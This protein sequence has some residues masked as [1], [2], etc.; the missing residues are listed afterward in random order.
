[1][2]PEP[3]LD[4]LIESVADGRPIDWQILEAAAVDDR[5]RRRLRQLKLVAA[6]AEVHSSLPDDVADEAVDSFEP[7]TGHTRW[8][9]LS[10][11]DKIG[12]GGFGEVFHARDPW[13]DRDVAL[14]LLKAAGPSDPAT[15]RVL[16]EARTLARIR[17]P[18]V[19]TVYGADRHDARGGMWME[20]VRGRTLADLL[21]KHG[22]FS[23]REAASVCVDLCRALAAIH[24][25]GLVHRDIKAQNVMRED[26]GRIVLMDLGNGRAIRAANDRGKPDLTGTP[27]YLAPEL[28]DGTPA[29]ERS[30]LYSLGVL[31]YHLV[32]DSYPVQAATLDDLE[33]AHRAGRGVRLRDA[34]PDLPGVFVR[35][36]DR[37]IAK[38]PLERHASA[39]ELEADLMRA[40]AEGA[41]TAGQTAN[42]TRR[43]AHWTGLVAG[44]G[45]VATI[46]VGAVLSLP[47][48]WRSNPNPGS[49]TIRSI[50]VLPLDNLSGDS[51]QD[52]FADGMTDELIATLGGLESVSVISRTSVQR[53]KGS[54]QRVADICRTLN[55]DAVIEGT[56]A[57]TRAAG[58]AN[59][60]APTDRVRINARLILAG[61]DTQIWG[62]SFES[63]LSDVLK[64]QADVARSV[65][66]SIN[67]IVTPKMQQ[68][69]ASA[70]GI[71]SEAFKLYLLGR[72]HWSSRRDA[73]DL[74][75][76]VD[77]FRE[78]IRRDPTYARSYAGLADS[79]VLLTGNFGRFSPIA[80]ASQASAAADKAIELDSLLAEPHVSLAYARYFLQWDWAD[81]EAEFKRALE[82]NPSYATAFDLYGD[83]LSAM[84]RDEEAI[85]ATKRALAL[86]PLSIVVS[87][88]AAWPLFFARRYPEA[89]AQ[90]QQTL[91]LDST[92]VAATSLLGRAYI[93]N[94]Q[95]QE[96]LAKLAWAEQHTSVY[97]YRA[98]LA[99]GYARAGQRQAAAG[100]LDGLKRPPSGQFVPPYDIALIYA[101]LGDKVQA[102]D[103]LERAYRE[104]D[105]TLVNVR[106]DPRFQSLDQEPRFAALIARM[107][108]PP[109]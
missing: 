77:F 6:I 25:A 65:A 83:F 4:A 102:I 16:R 59:R 53:Y 27:L 18:N 58:D 22:A 73:D 61:G 81:A 109:R 93:E 48:L 87:R 69:L 50:A 82:L 67:I 46:V 78:A 30:D 85:Q 107:R 63:D 11:L 19:V 34:R 12:E 35:V 97:R 40:F 94:G 79:Y 10:L 66:E 95:F 54:T 13:L 86:D 3:A 31:L 100:L 2:R 43:R 29:N 76:A 1:M 32:T 38:D 14:K 74:Q 75:K 80:G 60:S 51:A 108:F 26:G 101:A 64:L 24:A 17:H 36:V 105:A 89:I 98:Q 106:H 21:E 33:E 5:A 41:L 15:S 52:Y 42:R 88:G 49:R 56:V 92:Y 45:I 55:V 70:Q 39:G 7:A 62:R 28:F 84:G 90:L 57:L 103:W 9:H 99:Q 71:D 8:G 37:A 20:L 68:R 44:L 96:G 23:A 91:K 72:E 47:L 104:H